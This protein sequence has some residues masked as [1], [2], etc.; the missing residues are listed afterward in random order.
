MAVEKEKDMRI[1]EIKIPEELGRECDALNPCPEGE[2]CYLFE[3]K[4][5]A[6]CWLGDPCQRCESGECNIA[7]SYP[8]QV[9]CE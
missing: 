1:P 4:T 3:G 8:M 6:F 9:F 2:E 5:K 7:E